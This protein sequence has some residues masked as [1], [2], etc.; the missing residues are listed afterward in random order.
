MHGLAEKIEPRRSLADLVL[1]EERLNQLQE[2][3]FQVEQRNRVY[4]EWG[5]STKLSRGKGISALF[6]G[7]S[8]TGKTMAA[9][10]LAGRLNLVL[11]RIDLAGWIS[12]YIAETEKN[13]HLRLYAAAQS[14]S[15]LIFKHTDPL[16]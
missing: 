1:Q 4:E 15:L 16:L 9:E 6:A 14:A 11:S 3:V 2:I 7:P 10:V 8:G 5:F 13:L 12:K